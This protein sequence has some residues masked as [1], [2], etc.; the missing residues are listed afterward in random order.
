MD[1][2][3][4]SFQ[5]YDF[6]DIEAKWQKAWAESRVFAS[7]DPSPS[8]DPSKKFYCL[9]MFP[10]PSGKIHMGHA[11]NYCIGDVIARYK[12]MKGFR[13]LHPL[14]W[15]AFGL[16]AENAAIE[17][18]VNPRDWTEQNIKDMRND[19]KTLGISYDWDREIATCDPDYYRWNQWFFIQMF[20]KGLA[21]RKKS[22][23]NWCPKCQTV[24]ANEQVHDGKCWRCHSAVAQKDLEQWFLKITEYAE[25]LL[26]DTKLLEG[27][28]PDE[29]IT[30][31]RNWIGKSEGAEVHFKLESGETL[32]VFTTR[33]DTLHGCTFMV[34]AP[35]H[36]VVAKLTSK[37]VR[38][39]CEAAKKKSRIE[40]TSADKDKSG[41]FT[42]LYAVNPLNGSK[43]PVWTADYVLSDYGTGAIMAVPAHDQRDFDFAR[44]YQLPVIQ[45]IQS[46][47]EVKTPL[48][49]AYEGDG[50]LMNSGDFNGLSVAEAQKKISQ[51]L[52]EKGAG[53]ASVTFRIRDWLLSRQRYW[54]TPI[55]MMSCPKCG[56]VPEDEKN[57]PVV[58]PR[59]VQFTGKGESPLAQVKEFVEAKCTKCGGPARRETDTMDTFM[60]SSWYFMRYCDPKNSQQPFDPKKGDFWVPVDQYIGGIEHACMHLIYSRFFYK[61]IGDLGLA[62]SPEPFSRLLTQ[63]MVTLGG[64][65]MSKSKGNIVAVETMANEYGADTARIFI[66]FASPPRNQL[67]W[68]EDG[69]QGA[70]RF[71]NRIWK[72]SRQLSDVLGAPPAA[73][74]ASAVEAL[75]RKTHQTIKKVGEDIERDFQFNTA[76]A[77]LME[78]LNQLSEYP[79]LGDDASRQ[80]FKAMITLLF[81]FAPHIASEIW[82][83]CAFQPKSLDAVPFPS[84]DEKK[85]ARTTIE[86]PLAIN[87]RVRERA[88][89]SVED[90]KDRQKLEQWARALLKAKGVKDESIKKIIAVPSKMVNCA[91]ATDGEPSK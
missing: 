61:V 84:Y 21:Y 28:W 8:E 27:K 46:P 43:V 36:P 13:I 74:P 5:S 50:K 88:E 60:D 31:Q 52:K 78:L 59:N 12:K 24:L 86:I 76:I 66:L 87:G 63:G 39:Y 2:I 89:F 6:K 49:K 85:L 7:P 51:W 32:T 3:P 4:M 81:P 80:S 64:S 47:P 77:A 73:A 10:Y 75:E 56:L 58:L 53:Q 41:V 72:M 90:A 22:S 19:I 33:P 67:E 79:A 37:E 17:R 35:E 55:P 82:E 45:V 38:D 16:P 34:L 62:N 25:R 68:S 20:K 54:G 65:A 40:R 44:K 14:G 26:A 57:L 48:Q 30:M 83:D 42:G 18:G 9:V 69:V 29:V 15:D 23:V 11:R 91:V 70:W 71:L 1:S